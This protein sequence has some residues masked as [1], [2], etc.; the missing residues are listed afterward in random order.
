MDFGDV[1]SLVFIASLILGPVLQRHASNKKA[2]AASQRAQK[3]FEK[4]LLEV[5]A[6]QVECILA[7]TQGPVSV[8][9]VVRSKHRLRAPL[10][11]REAVGY[12][13]V[14]LV[15]SELRRRILIDISNCC[16]YEIFNPGGGC[17]GIDKQ[18]K[19]EVIAAE[20][21]R[22]E[23]AVSHLDDETLQIIKDHHPELSKKEIRYLWMN[24]SEWIFSAKDVVRVSGVA[25]Q[26]L[27]PGEA[28]DPYRGSAW[29]W[30]IGSD[31]TKPLL[32]CLGDDQSLMSSFSK[33]P[34]E[35]PLRFFL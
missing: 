27:A 30:M 15:G 8:K 31:E 12:R 21:F 10:S 18:T 5:T 9:G 1:S 4:E 14:G 33:A 23:L 19:L 2:Q 32:V 26:V 24:W 25:R 17:V 35:L 11:G 7:L 22:A 34:F 29:R 6:R 16:S 20:P 13:L 3:A 28:S